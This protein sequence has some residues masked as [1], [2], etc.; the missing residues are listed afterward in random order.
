MAC[1]CKDIDFGSEENF[2]QQIMV[3]IPPHMD[4]YKQARLNEGL[5]DKICID[6]CIIDEVK[7]LWSLGIKT[8]GCCCGHNKAE[9]FVNV[10]EK[11]IQKML[12]LGYVQ[13][14]QDKNRKDTFRLKSV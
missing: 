3:D 14:H 11:D 8:L 4:G 13:N 5:S 6:P 10:H 12:S 7:E 9:P 2:A 1:N